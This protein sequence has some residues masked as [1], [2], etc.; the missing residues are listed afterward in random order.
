MIWKFFRKYFI[1]GILVL[2]PLIITGYIVIF[3]FN[4]G[5]GILRNLIQYIAGR[6]IP[7]LGFLIMLVI[8]FLAG[9][10][11]HNVVGKK[12][13]MWGE[14]GLR[15]IPV[16]NSI[17]SASK[18]VMEAFAS[19]RNGAFQQVVLVEYP[20]QGLYMIGFLTGTA[21][22]MIK[23]QVSQDLVNVFVPATPPSHGY[24]VMVPCQDV[25]VLDMSVEEGLKLVLSGGIITSSPS[26]RRSHQL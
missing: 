10:F 9:L 6:R 23:Q 4:L 22:V 17:Y 8:V 14:A 11:G 16:V 13:L 21:P 7:G 18:Q 24:F 1:T 2:L 5:D 3:A 19:G 15:R 25:Q 20:R 12:L 26:Y